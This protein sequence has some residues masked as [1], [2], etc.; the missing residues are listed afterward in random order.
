MPATPADPI[1]PPPVPPTAA[2]AQSTE[3]PA[4]P[5][6]PNLW[7]ALGV[8]LV[9]FVVQL[10]FGSLGGWLI[11][12][13]GH[14]GPA[15]AVARANSISLM[16]IF[17]LVGAAAIV[18]WLT[19]R[20]WPQA[21][22]LGPPPGFGLARPGRGRFYALAVLIGLATPILGGLLT[23]WLAQGHPVPQDIK[24][25]GDKASL[26]LRIPLALVVIS[27]GPLVEE[28]LFRGVLLSALLGIGRSRPAMAGRTRWIAILL[29]ALIFGL[30]HL[31]DLSFFWY[32]VPNLM[33]LGVALAWLR[34][35][36]GSL[37]PAVLAHGCNNLLA[38]IAWFV[39]VHPG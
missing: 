17:T 37:W 31:P 27:V 6:S 22:S 18:L 20:L 32:A 38:V 15:D 36:A 14:A 30:L 26:A 2:D 13:L 7:Q 10:V 24:Q 11:R 9:Y 8:L 16:V 29:S 3:P 35:R 33:L 19:R 25:L 23:H 12:V 4:L 21:W 39:V 34:L 5:R 1:Q 28:L